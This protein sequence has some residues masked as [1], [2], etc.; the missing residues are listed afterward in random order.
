[1]AAIRKLNRAYGYY[2]D[3]GLWDDVA[4]LFAD[5]AVANYPNGTWVGRESIRKHLLQN[6]GGGR[7]GHEDGRLYSHLILQPVIHLDPGGQTARGRWRTLAMIGRYGGSASWAGGVYEMAYVKEGGAW[8]IAQLDYYSGFGASYED[9][10]GKAR[11][12][13]AP[14]PR[15]KLAYPPDRPQPAELA[16]PGYPAACLAPF[17]YQN[18]VSGGGGQVWPAP[19]PG[20]APSAGASLA[21]LARRAQALDD[22]QQIENLVGVYGYYLDRGLWDQAAALFAD[23]GELDLMGQGDWWGRDHIRKVL[24]TFGPRGG[25]DGWLGDHLQMEPVV[26][27]TSALGYARVRELGMSGRYQGK[28]YWSSGVYENVFVKQR[29]VWKIRRL[30]FYPDFV[31]DYDKGWGKDAE[32]AQGPPGAGGASWPMYPKARIA[33]YHFTN[34][35]T[36]KPTHYPDSMGQSETLTVPTAPLAPAGGAAPSLAEAEALMAKV[37]AVDEVENL[38]DAY[39]YYLDKGLWDEVA[40]L[41]AKDGAFELGQRGVYV[42]QAHIRSFMKGSFGPAGPQPDQMYNHILT[43]PVIDIAPDG[44]SARIRI[45]ELQQFAGEDGPPGLGEA[46][47][48][49]VAVLEGG[50]WKLQSLH[51]FQTLLADYQGGWAKAPRPQAP[52]PSKDDPPDRRPTMVYAP[53]PK[54]FTVPFHYPGPKP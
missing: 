21:D 37:K 8:K 9:G 33:L 11:P 4:D 16:C 13:G 38:E 15:F 28:G 31:T 5:N 47:D 10:W 41:F 40:D 1:V 48:E 53:F 44:A 2:V 35:V 54:T 17:H 30:R 52:G 20:A 36:G 14:G 39:G 29:G 6:L 26:D 22:E 43:Q 50:V 34:R 3:D 45:R 42:G 49:N 19:E 27:L 46:V 7:I 23:D 24:A 12:A 25:R 51:A 32:P 18:P